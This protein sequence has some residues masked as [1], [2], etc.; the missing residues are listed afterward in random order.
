MKDLARQIAPLHEIVVYETNDGGAHRR[1]AQK[2]G[3]PEP[4]GP[5]DQDPLA[6]EVG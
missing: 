5:H 3:A 6:R 2:S 1:E 4:S